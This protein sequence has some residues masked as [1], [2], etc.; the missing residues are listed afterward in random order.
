MTTKGTCIRLEKL[1]SFQIASVMN[2]V[3]FGGALP[4]HADWPQGSPHSMY[5][6]TGVILLLAFYST[7]F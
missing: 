2:A 7:L 6:H 1:S 5:V 3:E 4:N